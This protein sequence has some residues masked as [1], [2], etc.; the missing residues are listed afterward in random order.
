MAQGYESQLSKIQWEEEDIKV[1]QERLEKERKEKERKKTNSER[2]FK[3]MEQPA[4]SEQPTISEQTTRSEQLA[5]S[6]STTRGTLNCAPADA[7]PRV[8][9]IQSNEDPRSRPAN[10]KDKNNEAA[11]PL[12]IAL[13]WEP[14]ERSNTRV[15]IVIVTKIRGCALVRGNARRRELVV[16]V[17]RIM[18]VVILKGIDRQYGLVIRQLTRGRA[19]VILKGGKRKIW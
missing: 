1:L 12:A 7:S 15:G 2:L 19:L 13:R 11:G 14:S 10:N 18:V 6:G 5:T 4:R 8:E 3:E 9:R 17:K 16:V